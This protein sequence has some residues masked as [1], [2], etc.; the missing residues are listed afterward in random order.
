M[1]KAYIPAAGASFWMVVSATDESTGVSLLPSVAKALAGLIN[2][3]A[4]G[5]SD[6][7]GPGGRGPARPG[8]VELGT[9]ADVDVFV[10]SEATLTKGDLS[11]AD[12]LEEIRVFNGLCHDGTGSVP[13]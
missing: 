11:S 2:N 3:R 1:G 12:G 9:S 5:R 6:H 4:E 8:D 13:S 7:R 10:S